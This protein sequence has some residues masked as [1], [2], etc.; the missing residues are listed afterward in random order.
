MEVVSLHLIITLH[1]LELQETTSSPLEHIKTVG[2]YPYLYF[3]NLDCILYFP[4]SFGQK[5]WKLPRKI[6]RVSTSSSNSVFIGDLDTL[7][8]VNYEIKPDFSRFHPNFKSNV[9]KT[10][11]GNKLNHLTVLWDKKFS[12]FSFSLKAWTFPATNYAHCFSI[13]IWC[14]VW[15]CIIFFRSV[16]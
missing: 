2:F 9:A 15:R 16:A 10:S 4:W 12:F 6:S 11:F 5:F 1:F 8:H 7:N 13:S 14:L 3:E